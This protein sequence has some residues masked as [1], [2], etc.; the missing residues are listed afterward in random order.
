MYGTYDAE[1]RPDFG[2]FCWV[3][4]YH[5]DAF[6]VMAAICEDKRTRDNIRAT[7]AFS[8]GLVT[9]AQL[10]LADHFGCTPGHQ[11]GKMD[12]P[13]DIEKGRVLNVPVLADCPWTYELQVDNTFKD[14]GADIY[15]CKIRNVL[16]AESLCDASLSTEQKL[17]AIRPVHA[18]G[19]ASYFSWDGRLLG[20]WGEPMKALISGT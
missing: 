13:A 7:G 3:S 8:M 17:G 19:D 1:G 4:Y 6:G 5:S 10:P 2:L 20:K 11:P 16:A 9:E 15:L 12:V 18:I 14:K